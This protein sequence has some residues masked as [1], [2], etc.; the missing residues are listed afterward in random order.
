MPAPADTVLDT[1]RLRLRLVTPADASFIVQ[2]L[3]DPDFLAQIG[4][5]GV[6]TASDA[7]RYIAK[8]PRASYRRYGFGLWVVQLRRRRIAIGLCGLLHRD[9]HP[10]VEIGYALL[11]RF[12]RRGYALEA[13]HATLRHAV[14]ALG[15]KRIMAITALDNIDSIKLLS[16]IGFEYQGLVRFTGDGAESRLFACQRTRLGTS[17]RSALGSR[18]SR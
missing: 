16:R 6:R 8:G 12:R 11:S 2:L 3:N 1:P 10:D 13:A 14:G 15:I 18:R 17:R 7:R 9:S 5:R 4:D